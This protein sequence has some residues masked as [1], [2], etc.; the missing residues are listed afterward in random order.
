M[1]KIRSI[2][3]SFVWWLDIDKTI[4]NFARLQGMQNSCAITA[5]TVDLLHR[6]M[7]KNL[8]RSFWIIPKI[9]FTSCWHI[10]Q[11]RRNRSNSPHYLPKYLIIEI[12]R[13][14]F[15]RF[16]IPRICVFDIMQKLFISDEFQKFL[17]RQ[18]FELFSSPPYHL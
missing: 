16:G 3:R 12:L 6:G 11:M 5:Q 9:L 13:N 17:S 8:L 4:E 14:I 7:G 15:A 10:R 18:N 1:V 2:A